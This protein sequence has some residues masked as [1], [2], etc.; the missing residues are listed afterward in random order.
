MASNNSIIHN[1]IPGNNAKVGFHSVGEWFAIIFGIV[2]ILVAIL[3]GVLYVF[4]WDPKR[5]CLKKV[6]LRNEI[7]K[8][9]YNTGKAELHSQ[10]T[11]QPELASGAASELDGVGLPGREIDG[12]MVVEM[13]GN[14]GVWEI[15]GMGR[16]ELEV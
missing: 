4:V 12:K 16:A 9:F 15:D 14:T 13:E 6:Q 8:E 7:E 11:V 2:G 5:R 1:D 10:D 3:L